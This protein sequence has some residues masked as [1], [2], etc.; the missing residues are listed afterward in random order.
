MKTDYILAGRVANTHGVR[1]E[2]RLENYTD[3]PEF[4][5]QFK[6]LYIDGTAY[7]MQSAKA[8]KAMLIVKL[9]GVEDINAAM[10]FKGRRVEVARAEAKL[11]K[12]AFF[13]C[14]IMGAK[15]VEEDGTELGV[16]SDII[17][18]P[19]SNVYVVKGEREILIPAVPEFIKSTDAEGGVITVRLI[20]GM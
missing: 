18:T 11:P 15:V 14:D 1:G 16:L 5:K 3:S 2:L 9:E 4:L 8:H 6:T 12:G 17:E 13:L 7:K 10:R 19:S 20:E